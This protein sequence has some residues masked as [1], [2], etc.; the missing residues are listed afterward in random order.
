VSDAALALAFLL[1][2][3]RLGA[4]VVRGDADALLA[5]IPPDMAKRRLP[6][7]ATVEALTGALDISATLA[8]GRPVMQPGLMAAVA[9]GVLIVPMAERLQ[10]DIAG[11]LAAALDAAAVRLILLDSGHDTDLVPPS[12]LDRA[13]FLVDAFDHLIDLPADLPAVPASIPPL[14]IDVAEQIAGCAVALG[15]GSL[16]TQQAALRVAAQT[17]VI[18]A[19]RLVLAPRAT[20]WPET[21]DVPPPDH[22]SEPLANESIGALPDQILDAVQTLLPADAI[23]A[24]VARNARVK[25]VGR[26]ARGRATR[27]GRPIG[28][29]AGLPRG[30]ARLALID[31][32][33]AAA[34]WQRVRGRTDR[35]IIR[36]SDLRIRRLEAR[37]ATTTIFAVDASGSAAAARMAEAKGAVEHLLAR[38]YAE[39]AHV[40]VV[41]FRGDEASILVPPT[42]S[43]TRA[44]RLLAELPGGGTTPLAAGLSAARSL[45]LAERGRGHSPRI[46][47][48]TDGRANAPLGSAQLVA[49]QEARAIAREAIPATLIDISA[50]PRAEGR[51]IA[52]AMLARYVALP[53]ADTKGVAAALL[54]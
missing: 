46:I 45:A 44:R 10:P 1:A 8:T 43:L 17:S 38:A 9:G 4:M 52:A 32:L 6:V 26:G 40:A 50:R 34:P 47:V 14:E 7:S 39:R 30:G 21:S 53:R 35:I 42:R 51:S 16:R 41:A 33:R 48:L 24:I 23:A 11:V 25:S 13:A 22:S 36:K 37:S 54:P 27:H 29:R 20:R 3:A 15:V 19:I 31:T 49:D 18:D 28:C 2:D 5:L 12:L